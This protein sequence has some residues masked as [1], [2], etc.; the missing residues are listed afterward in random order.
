VRVPFNAIVLGME[1]L[2][3]DISAQPPQMQDALETINILNEQSEVVTHIL[4]DVMVLQR[5]EGLSLF[6]CLEL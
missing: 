4:N 2:R 1:Q 6:A 5:I 3:N